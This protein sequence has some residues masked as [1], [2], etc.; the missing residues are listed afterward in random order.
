MCKH[1]FNSKVVF[2]SSCCHKWWEC[3]ECHDEQSDHEFEFVKRLKMFCK[4]CSRT[5]ERDLKLIT[6]KDEFCYECGTCWCIPGETP[7]SVL[8]K[9]SLAL[10]DESLNE[11]LENAGSRL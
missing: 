5:F 11:L 1:I 8:Y 6:I 2:R 7:E 4:V 10:L 9:E 3:S